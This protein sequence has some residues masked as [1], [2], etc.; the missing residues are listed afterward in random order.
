MSAEDGGQLDLFGGDSPDPGGPS[1]ASPLSHPALGGIEPVLPTASGFLL[2]SCAWQ[3]ESFD[4]CFYPPRLANRDQ[5]PFYARHFNAVEIDASFYR[6]PA[7]RT[8]DRW[9]AAT[10][11]TFRFALKA[12]RTLTHKGRLDLAHPEAH[13]D[14]NAFLQV[15]PLFRHKLAAVLLQLGPWITYLEFDKLRRVLDT[16][17]PG[18]PVA[19]EFR[20]TTWNRPDVNEELR[21]RAAVRAWVDQYNDSGRGVDGTE[22]DLFAPTG[23]FRY[24][25]LLGNVAIKYE[26]G[27]SR[28]RFAYGDVLFERED[29]LRGW[30]RRVAG[31][32][33]NGI[34]VHLFINNHYQGFAPT[35]A[36]LLLDLVEKEPSV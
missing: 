22:P 6:V 16:L 11:D 14:W 26:R 15:L 24:V 21:Q 33:G 17:R 31:E 5:L 27:T 18:T 2:G 10:P 4:R 29:D 1:S 32:L 20:H 35:T 7:P 25:R 12:P 8:V 28:R 23:P 9:V 30:A 34:P 13:A 36:K 3:H 19:I